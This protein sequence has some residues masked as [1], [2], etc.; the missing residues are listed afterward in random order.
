M[1]YLWR[2]L[3]PPPSAVFQAKWSDLNPLFKCPWNDLQADLKGMF[4]G[5]GVNFGLPPAQKI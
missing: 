4:W 3:L 5:V 2:L 1:E